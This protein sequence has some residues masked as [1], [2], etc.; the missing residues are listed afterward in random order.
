MGIGGGINMINMINMSAF[1]LI[2][3]ITNH[4]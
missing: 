2:D 3:L 4:F 1:C